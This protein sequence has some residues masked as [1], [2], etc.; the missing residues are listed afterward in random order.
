MHPRITE[1]EGGVCVCVYVCA[2]VYVR[3]RNFARLLEYCLRQFGHPVSGHNAK[4]KRVLLEALGGSAGNI[5]QPR[6]LLYPALVPSVFLSLGRQGC[7][8]ASWGG[9]AQRTPASAAGQSQ[10]AWEYRSRF[11]CPALEIQWGCTGWLLLTRISSA[12]QTICPVH[13]ATCSAVTTL[14]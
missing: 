8:V 7:C 10:H 9:Q 3:E 11:L 2:H 13:W 14:L 1:V 4:A 12:A 5:A 6:F